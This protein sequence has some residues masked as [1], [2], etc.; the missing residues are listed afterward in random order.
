MKWP[1]IAIFIA[2]IIGIVALGMNSQNEFEREQI[3]NSTPIEVAIDKDPIHSQITGNM[4]RNTKYGFRIKFPKGWNI[5][6]GDGIH[7][8]QK[9]TSGLESIMISVNQFESKN[10]TLF[11][12]EDLTGGLQSAVDEFNQNSRPVT[13]YEETTLD[14]LPAYMIEYSTS[15]KNLD[16]EA[17]I[18]QLQFIVLKDNIIYTISAGTLTSRYEEM[19]E[20]FMKS[21]STFVVEGK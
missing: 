11:S 7:I 4:Y 16:Q 12:I 13:F 6:P 21:I 10:G 15:Y 14:N 20:E 5:S 8:V 3:E 1:H 18:T 2:V 9:A 19:K 17:D